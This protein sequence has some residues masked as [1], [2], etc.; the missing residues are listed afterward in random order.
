MMS[1]LCYHPRWKLHPKMHSSKFLK[2]SANR[3]VFATVFISF[4]GLLLFKGHRINTHF[5]YFS[6]EKYRNL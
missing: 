4:K 3:R 2:Y 6:K 5:I 1:N